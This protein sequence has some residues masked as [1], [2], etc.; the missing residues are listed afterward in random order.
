MLEKVQ[1]DFD[2]KDNPIK[3]G[4]FVDPNTGQK[5][6]EI[7]KTIEDTPELLKKHDEIIEKKRIEYHD[8]E[9]H[10]KLVG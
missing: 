8:R 2:E 7:L 5:I 4:F 6:L 9:S 3:P 1:I 10:R